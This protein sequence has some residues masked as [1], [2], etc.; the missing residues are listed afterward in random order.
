MS[1]ENKS[2]VR[3]LVDEAQSGGNLAVVDEILAADFVDASPF[4]GLP[5]TRDGV[6]MLFGALRTAFPDLHV[7]ISEQ[8]AE[9]DKV[10]TRKTFRGT[11]NGPFMTL[12]ASGRSVEWEV[13]DILTFRERRIVGHRVIFD[14]L[15]FLR[16]LGALG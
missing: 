4:E 8:V 13:I 5:P 14:Q 16:Q 3:R 15:G 10:V 9:G 12:P 7:T 1:D 6:R 11:Q 2:L